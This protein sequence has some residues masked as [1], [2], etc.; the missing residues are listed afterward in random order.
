MGTRLLAQWPLLTVLATLCC[1]AGV[2]ATG[3]WRWASFILGCGVSLAAF[4]RLVLPRR[5]I[6]L[7][8]VRSRWFDV[9]VTGLMGLGIVALTLIVPPMRP[10]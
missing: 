3:H 10:R 1:G 7:L 8:A 4:W 6:G 5:L 2:A 9:A